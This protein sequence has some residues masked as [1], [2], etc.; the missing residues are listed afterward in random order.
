M[1][2]QCNPEL[3]LLSDNFAMQ[4]AQA[5]AFDIV[6][7]LGGLKDPQTGLPM[8]YVNDL[9]S[10]ESGGSGTIKAMAEVS[11]RNNNH[12]LQIENFD[13]WSS[14][15]IEDERIASKAGPIRQDI[16]NAMDKYNC[17][18]EGHHNVKEMQQGFE[19]EWGIK[20]SYDP[21]TPDGAVYEL[22][23]F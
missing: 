11:L 21:S 15:K 2:N 9:D 13:P 20:P 10:F 18:V 17:A 1:T 5:E 6:V 12:T 8:V 14:D 23:I 3:A 4:V 7:E 16:I 19:E 22:K